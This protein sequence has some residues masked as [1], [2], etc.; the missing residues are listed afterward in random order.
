MV[1]TTKVQ[2]DTER[3]EDEECKINKKGSLIYR[4]RLISGPNRL[5]VI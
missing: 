5:P 1:L 3:E 4:P 2:H